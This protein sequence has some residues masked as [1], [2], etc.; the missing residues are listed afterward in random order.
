MPVLNDQPKSTTRKSQ[1]DTPAPT[2]QEANAAIESKSGMSR[3]EMIGIGSALL[4]SGGI[5]GTMS[6]WI[7]NEKGRRAEVFIAK[8]KDYGVDLTRPIRDGLAALEVRPSEI[9]GKS[10]LLKPNLVEATRGNLHVNTNPALVVAA[11]DVFR[12]MGAREV[13]VAEGQGHRRDTQ[14]VLDVSRIGE[15]LRDARIP[16]VD[17][18]HDEFEPV[19]VKGGWTKLEKLYLPKTILAADVVVSMPKLKTHHWAGMTCAMKNLFGIM[20]GIVYGWPKN[21]L[22][23]QGIDECILDINATLPSTL[24]IVDGIVGME[25]DGPIMGTPKQAGCIIVGRNAPA[26][27]A[28]A[29]RVMGLNAY[30]LGYLTSASGSLGP[31]H[32]RNITQRGERIDTVKTKFKVLDFPHLA[33]V[34]AS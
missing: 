12:A 18:N 1:R 4:M 10:V 31:I 17:L 8:A 13:I 25:G 33:K 19:P 29:A 34:V 22:H 32:E 28:T 15:A 23:L 2:K 9:A 30:G 16:F 20:P 11:A 26:V 7:R 6:H 21:V 24:S 14:Y 3:R 5:A 27:D